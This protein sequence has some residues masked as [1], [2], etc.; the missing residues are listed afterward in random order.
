MTRGPEKSIQGQDRHSPKSA[1][2]IEGFERPFDELPR[3]STIPGE[4]SV[5]AGA[6]LPP[7]WPGGF[8]YLGDVSRL[9]GSQGPCLGHR[10]SDS[11]GELEPG[12]GLARPRTAMSA[13]RPFTRKAQRRL[14]REL[15]AGLGLHVSQDSHS[16][17]GKSSKA[18]L[19]ETRSPQDVMPGLF[20]MATI[21]PFNWLTTMSAQ[22]ETAG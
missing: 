4:A 1:F 17:Q 11:D 5:A 18:P 21:P 14:A 22:A 15:C 6:K 2:H 9:P 8:G 13:V 16:A 7:P 10:G 19:W 12:P 20:L 3:A